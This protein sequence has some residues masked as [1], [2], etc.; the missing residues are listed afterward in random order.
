MFT[1]F[2]LDQSKTCPVGGWGKSE[3]KALTLAKLFSLTMQEL[4]NLI[5]H[6]SIGFFFGH[7][8]GFNL[9][10]LKRMGTCLV[11]SNKDKGQIKD[12]V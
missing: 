5:Y 12:K 9:Y 4:Q 1:V 11:R 10:L 6:F 2:D 7:F 3:I 8:C